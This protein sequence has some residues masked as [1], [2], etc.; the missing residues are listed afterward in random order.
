LQTG[1]P[2]GTLSKLLRER[3]P[4]YRAAADFEVDTS[5]L[6]DQEVAETI[7]RSMETL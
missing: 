5:R 3:E 4:I 1:D 6:T 7:L 2:R